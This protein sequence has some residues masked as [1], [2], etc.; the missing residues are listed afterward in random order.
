[1]SKCFSDWIILQKACIST[2]H[3]YFFEIPAYAN[4][5]VLQNHIFL[6]QCWEHNNQT[7]NKQKYLSK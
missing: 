4:L 1:M 6:P 5:F 2:I 3:Q 7:A